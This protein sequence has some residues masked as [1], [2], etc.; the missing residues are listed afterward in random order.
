[1]MSSGV[2]FSLSELPERYRAQVAGKLSPRK[3]AP[4]VRRKRKVSA[5][6]RMAKRKCGMNSTEEKFNRDVLLGIGKYE[7]ITLHLSGGNYTPDFVF[8]DPNDG[9]VCLVEVKGSYRLP[10]MGRSVFAFK[11]ACAEFPMFRFLFAELGKDGRTW[12]IGSYR[13]GEEVTT[14]NGTAERLHSMK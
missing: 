8:T 6:I 11:Q 5:P 1:M 2:H 9:E 4:V 3:E 12:T 13:G 10:S 14:V 7:A